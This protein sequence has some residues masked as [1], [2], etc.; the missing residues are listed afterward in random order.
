MK[1][2]LLVAA[3]L[4][5]ML[6]ACSSK[7]DDSIVA[8]AYNQ[9]LYR[10]DIEGL[11]APGTTEED[12]IAI[13]TNYIN[14]WIQQQVV[15]EKAKRN[16]NNNFD[17]EL[18]NYRNSL[19]TY[20]YE[21]TIVEQLLDTNVS[22]QEIAEYYSANSQNFRLRTNIVK[23]AYMVVP[24]GTPGLAQMRKLIKQRSLTDAEATEL[25]KLAATYAS[26]YSFDSETWTPFYLFQSKI[27]VEV[28]NELDFLNQNRVVDFSDD[29]QTYLAMIFEYR[30]VDQIAPLEYEAPNIR[31]II[32][33]RRKIDIIKTMQR[34]LLKEANNKGEIE[35]R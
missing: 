9:Y 27:P 25:Q 7:H 4:S 14:Q 22:D 16:I 6:I 13:V 5:T 23:A 30:T 24:L 21:R 15:L 17:Q 32:L 33:N 11:V 8:R 19:I 35:I 10:S 28:T 18:Q 2:L 26:D 29:K 20:E 1:R 3:L 12:S 31:T 34:D